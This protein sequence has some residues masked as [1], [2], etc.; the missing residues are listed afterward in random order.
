M[1]GQMGTS[2]QADNSVLPM[3]QADKFKTLGITPPKGC[4]MY[5]P[6]GTGKT[7]LARAC[8][9]QTKA[10]Y[11]KLAGPSLVQVSSHV[12]AHSE[13]RLTPRCSSV[14]V[15]SSSETLSSWQRRRRRQ[16][17]SSMSS[18]RSERSGS[19]VTRREIEKSNERCWS[20]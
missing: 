1:S 3:Q 8:A 20:C 2:S 14:T 6:P 4:L 5:G 9:A 10:C 13:P 7:L 19:T 12:P 11:L 17:F 16:S 15:R 18:M